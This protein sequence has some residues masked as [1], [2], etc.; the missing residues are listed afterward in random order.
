EALVQLLEER[1]FPLDGL[2]LLGD[3]GAAGKRVEFRGSHLRIEPAASFDF[4]Q[5]RVAFFCAGAQTAETLA[6][7][8]AA[9]GAVVI[10]SSPQFR[11]AAD[12]PLVVAEVNGE[13]IAGFAARNLISSPSC[14]SIALAV[15]LK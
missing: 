2:V 13:D 9:A 10:D 8:A 6:P 7:R 14:G 1:E 4:A 5:V 3:Q 11:D 15:A 12:V